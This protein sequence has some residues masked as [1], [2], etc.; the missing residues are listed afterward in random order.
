M[1]DGHAGGTAPTTL[2]FDSH[3]AICMH[4]LIHMSVLIQLHALA[5]ERLLML[6]LLMP[7]AAY[8]L[9]TIVPS[10]CAVHCCAVSDAQLSARPRPIVVVWLRAISALVGC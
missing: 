10:I 4:K 2:T 9:T 8:L 6:P 1:A 3:V 7:V 5:F